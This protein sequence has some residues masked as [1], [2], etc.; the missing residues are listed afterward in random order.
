MSVV[1]SYKKGVILFHQ[2][3]KSRDLYF[4]QKGRIRIFRNHK[5][6]CV[7]LAV[8]EQGSIFGE[9]SLIDGKPR[10]A[11]AQTLEE[12]DLLVIPY[13]EFQKLA[14]SVPEWY[15]QF[16]KIMSERLRHSN[17]RLHS[18]QRLQLVAT[19][20]QFLLLI[21]RKHVRLHSSSNTA[22]PALSLKAVKKEILQVLGINRE[23]M[24]DA[25]ETLKSQDLITFSANTLTLL[26]P[27][28]IGSFIQIVRSHQT[29]S[30]KPRLE[31]KF[32]ES[33]IS[34]R[35]LLDSQ[36]EKRD[37]VTFSLTHFKTEL[38][39]NLGL[40]ETDLEWFLM[41]AAQWKIARFFAA[42]NGECFK[43]KDLDKGGQIQFS[44]YIL[45]NTL[46][47]DRFFES[48]LF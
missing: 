42:D 41:S 43:Y 40:P 4:I 7:E 10:S 20:A 36:L 2:D 38:L 15:L 34:L 28:E 31:S 18:G 27:E 26:N 12:S 21:Q 30:P 8:L 17:E 9:M 25:L 19:L 3:T 47:Q 23:P 11:S 1:R 37:L 39:K 45:K 24:E 35:T 5:Q 13:Y 14:G 32:K 29:L 16:I 44:S 6:D 33:L 46:R 48:G 22:T